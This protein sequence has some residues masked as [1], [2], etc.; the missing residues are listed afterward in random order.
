M[1]LKI[2]FKLTKQ[3]AEKTG[4]SRPVSDDLSYVLGRSIKN[5]SEVGKVTDQQ[6]IDALCSHM[7]ILSE[8][9]N[10]TSYRVIHLNDGIQ[11]LPQLENR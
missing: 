10:L 8:V 2:I 11:V 1:E 9:L 3:D 6:M 7:P 5:M 4:H